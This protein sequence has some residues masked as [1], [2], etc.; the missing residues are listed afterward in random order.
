MR[1]L[2][3]DR[4]AECLADDWV[5]LVPQRELHHLH[6]HFDDATP[7]PSRRRFTNVLASSPPTPPSPPLSSPDA[8]LALAEES[9]RPPRADAP[10]GHARRTA[11][12]VR[13]CAT[14]LAPRGGAPQGKHPNPTK[15]GVSPLARP[16]VRNDDASRVSSPPE[17]FAT[18]G[19][20]SVRTR[21]RDDERGTSS[22]R[23][24]TRKRTRRASRALRAA[25]AVAATALA[26]A[27][28]VA[29]ARVVVDRTAP[30]F[31][32]HSRFLSDEGARPFSRVDDPRCARVSYPARDA[33]N[34]AS[35][36]ASTR[37]LA[38][39]RALAR[40]DAL[41]K[42]VTACDA[43]AN[44]WRRASEAWYDAFAEAIE[45]N[46]ALARR[47]KGDR[48]LRT[49]VRTFREGVLP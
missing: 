39:E 5:D 6:P 21:R 1:R 20:T 41:R 34:E 45:T 17:G 13:A 28:V 14:A 27:S 38:L 33:T 7:A 3:P 15:R 9:M 26:A 48:S 35:A 2:P 12:L 16:D 32:F 31:H 49:V 47:A 30:S 4:H 11:R 19:Q 46:A 43:A 10:G 22:T 37:E 24:C 25:V 44:A 40:A 29:L 18:V 8:W 42:N 23:G 36:I